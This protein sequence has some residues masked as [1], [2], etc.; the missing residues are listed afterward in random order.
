M[1]KTI[2]GL[3]AALLGQAL[4]NAGIDIAPGE[5][6][7]ALGGVITIG[8]IVLAWVER[9]KRGDITFYGKRIKGF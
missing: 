8:G 6:E 3:L 2:I 7:V 4:A 5:L 1:S 9:V